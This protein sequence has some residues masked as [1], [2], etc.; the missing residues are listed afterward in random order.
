M[1][2]KLPQD[3]L[4]IVFAPA[5]R[6]TWVVL[7]LGV[8]MLAGGIAMSFDS[9]TLVSVFGL[10]HAPR[11]VV[12][13]LVALPGLVM[14][15]LAVNAL[16]R[17]LPRLELTES[18]LILRNRLG[19]VTRVAWREVERVDVQHFERDAR[20]ERLGKMTFDSVAIVLTD[21]RKLPISELGP[22]EEMRDAI[23]RW[24]TDATS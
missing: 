9:S 21:G 22:A 5:R 17:G 23:M 11:S 6:D 7:A 4:P 8:A 3:Q 16:A 19:G 14:V 10:F 13:W 18:G 12:G 20:G 2:D 24:R 15:A 1:S